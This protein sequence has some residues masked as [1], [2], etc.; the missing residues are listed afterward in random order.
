MPK[1]TRSNNL[2]TED[3]HKQLFSSDESDIEDDNDSDDPI[4]RYESSSSSSSS[5]SEDDEVSDPPVRQYD[6]V[7]SLANPN[8]APPQIPSWLEPPRKR[9]RVEASDLATPA[10]TRARG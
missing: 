6:M 1:R 8:D 2:R 10:V 4:Y 3:I 5:S 9:A 7:Q